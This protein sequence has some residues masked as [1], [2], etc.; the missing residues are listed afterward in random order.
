M[1][2]SPDDFIP[3]NLACSFF[4]GRPHRATL[5]R[6]ALTGVMRHGRT[7]KLATQVSGGRRYTTRAA[8]EMFLNDCNADRAAKQAVPP[9]QRAE[10]AGR[11]LESRGVR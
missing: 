10:T 3:L 2:V 9:P 7:V 6:W 5:W 8:I 4:P 1:P 11:I